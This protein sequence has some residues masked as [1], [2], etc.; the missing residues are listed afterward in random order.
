MLSEYADDENKNYFDSPRKDDTLFDAEEY[1]QEVREKADEFERLKRVNQVEEDVEE[2]EQEEEPVDFNM[3]HTMVL[4]EK[5]KKQERS[6]LSSREK[7]REAFGHDEDTRNKTD[8]DKKSFSIAGFMSAVKKFVSEPEEDTNDYDEDDVELNGILSDTYSSRSK[9]KIKNERGTAKKPLRDGNA[10]AEGMLRSNT[11]TERYRSAESS[12]GERNTAKSMRTSSESAKRAAEELIERIVGL[13]EEDEMDITEPDYIEN[14]PEE[15]NFE[16]SDDHLRATVSYKESVVKIRAALEDDNKRIA[17]TKSVIEEEKNIRAKAEEEERLRAEEERKIFEEEAAKEREAERQKMLEAEKAKEEADRIV[18]EEAAERKRRLEEEKKASAEARLAEIKAEVEQEAKKAEEAKKLQKESDE[19]KSDENAE[20]LENTEK[21]SSE[22]QRQ[23]Q[24]KSK[25]SKNKKNVQ[26]ENV[27]V[28]SVAE[29]KLEDDKPSDAEQIKANEQT[30]DETDNTVKETSEEN[31][32]RDAKSIT[33]DIIAAA[34]MDSNDDMEEETLR[35][36]RKRSSKA[37]KQAELNDYDEDYFDDFDEDESI[38]PEVVKSDSPVVKKKPKTKKEVAVQANENDISSILNY[39]E[40]EQE[41]EPSA[42]VK[43]VRV[44][45]LGI[46]LTLVMLILVS[47]VT[48]MAYLYQKKQQMLVDAQNEIL[49]LKSNDSSAK[50]EAQIKE[51][52][53]QIADLTVQNEYLLG[54]GGLQSTES[55]TMSD[56]ENTE[57]TTADETEDSEKSE[58]ESKSENASGTYIVQS[59]D[60]FYSIAQKM[61]GDGS[62]YSDILEANGMNEQNAA[63][64]VGDEI[65]IP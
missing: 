34:T 59:G 14:P 40:D 46:I 1:M 27:R 64:V 6:T 19:V 63:L 29:K 42:T 2:P 8:E 11:K 38:M 35:R 62:R 55:T 51:L 9:A 65:K 45:V 15:N 48:G 28:E 7:Y 61:Y 22:N 17:E 5:P 56:V 47:A 49:E 44:P 31:M 24:K 21:N 4:R 32:K 36:S 26:S 58:D 39:E 41:E 18:R 13:S 16:E 30:T 57:K 37:R 10:A 25:K 33:N 53:N 3:L 52:E 20:K 23:R 43:V 54:G 12:V 50:Y 60:S